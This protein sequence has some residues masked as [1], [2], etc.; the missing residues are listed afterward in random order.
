MNFLFGF[1]FHFRFYSKVFFSSVLVL[2][3][4]SSL[5]GNAG[6]YLLVYRYGVITGYVTLVQDM[7]TNVLYTIALF[8]PL[9]CIKYP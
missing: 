4:V 9:S 5:D 2:F 6:S 7:Y 8:F 1:L 3:L